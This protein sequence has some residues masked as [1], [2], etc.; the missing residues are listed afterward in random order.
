MSIL[1][2]NTPMIRRCILGIFF[3]SFVISVGCDTSSGPTNPS[4]LPYGKGEPLP[5]REVKTK[6]T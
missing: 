3:L 2:E 6:S 5:K 1:M 4:D